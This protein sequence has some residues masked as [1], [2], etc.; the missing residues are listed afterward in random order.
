MNDIWHGIERIGET[1]L[2]LG[3]WSMAILMYGTLLF[4]VVLVAGAI[5]EVL[6]LVVSS[7]FV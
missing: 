6:W 7:P 5:L 1:L 4:A 2:V 3:M